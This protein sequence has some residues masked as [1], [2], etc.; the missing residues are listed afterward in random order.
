[1]KPAH[2][3]IIRENTIHLLYRNETMPRPRRQSMASF[4]NLDSTSSFKDLSRY[5][6]APDLA[7][8]LSAQRVRSCDMPMGGGLAFNWAASPIDAERLALLLR[9]AEEQELVEKLRLLA[10]GEMMNPGE[11]RLVLHHLCR[12][13]LAGRVVKEGRD[14]SAFYA[15][16]V[17]KIKAFAE[18][19]HKGRI[20]G[21]TGRKFDT[22]VQIGIGGS[23]LGPR[24][25]YLALERW[26]RAEGRFRMT[27]RFIS[28]VDPDD[29]DSV[30]GGIDPASSLFILVSKSGTT[31]ETLANET[32]VRTR[33]AAKGLD[34]AKHLLA[35]TSETSP[36]AR[37]PSYLA[38]FY[39]DDYIGGRYSSTSAVGGAVLSLAFGPETFAELLAGAHEEDL[40]ALEKDPLKNPALL[41][42]LIGVYER[43]VLGMAAT[44]VLP[45]S[46][47]LSRF[48]AHLQQLDMESNGKRV[49]RDGRALAYSTGPLVFGEPGTNGQH[50]FYQLLHQGTDPLPLQFIGFVENQVSADISSEGSTS[51]EKLNANLAA[52][53][54]AF[55]TGKSDSDANKHFPGGRPSTLIHGQRLDARALGALLAHYENKI[56]FQGFAWNLN[57]FDQEGV[58]LG[59]LL[60][61]KVLASRGEAAAAGTEGALTS[62]ASLLGLGK[63]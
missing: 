35:V 45:Y 27:A 25:L 16:E 3:Y 44:A 12:G 38:S 49:N 55:A 22:V 10:A 46:E 21:S 9:L 4:N 37:N 17:A 34:P 31:Q 19:V 1:M 40:L 28:N 54:F 5:T 24:A 33:L 8:L 20:L 29:A 13:E 6:E 52:Q 23:D 56:A 51:R 59:K 58:Q 48:P 14:Y 42:A 32:L 36:L 62:F 53:I 47:A 11:K 39:M 50:S 15:G 26:A 18:A 57:S 61:K 2:G 63:K 43:N 7:A 60:A 30:L 41:D